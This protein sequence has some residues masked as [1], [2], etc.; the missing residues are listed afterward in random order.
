MVDDFSNFSLLPQTQD[1]IYVDMLGGCGM[2]GGGR[3]EG[4]STVMAAYI[5]DPSPRHIKRLP[6]KMSNIDWVYMQLFTA[7][8]T[9][10]KQV[11]LI[12]KN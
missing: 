4:S 12:H 10:L 11:S 2:G 3:V 9:R 8:Y 5:H 1:I 6:P 7:T